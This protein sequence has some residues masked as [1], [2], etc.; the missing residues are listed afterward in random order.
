[1]QK[2][3]QGPPVPSSSKLWNDPNVL[4]IFG[5]SLSAIMGVSSVSPAFHQIAQALKIS[6]GE[7]SYLITFYTLPGV[8]LTPILGILADIFG[9]KFIL[10]PSLLLFGIAGTSCFFISDFEILLICRFFQGVGSAAL[11][12]L[13]ITLIG[14]L[15]SGKTRAAVMG[16]NSSVLSFGTGGYPILG[17]ALAT[18]GWNYPFL[19]P[20]L[21]VVVGLLVIF[22]LQNPEPQANK[23]VGKYLKDV[24]KYLKNKQMIGILTVS[25]LSFVIFFGVCLTYFP[26]FLGNKF[27]TS[28][29]LIGLILS[30]MSLST[31]IT[32]AQ[33]GRL[34]RKYSEIKLLK[35][36]FLFEA[37]SLLMI[38]FL[39]R[40]W[41]MFIPTFIFG[42]G[43]GLNF[44]NVQ[45][46][47]T[48]L[49]PLN[50]RA[51]I[52]SL[53]G[54]VLRVGQT[55]GPLLMAAV[56]SIWGYNAIFLVGVFL[57]IALVVLITFLLDQTLK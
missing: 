9:R 23:N 19:L 52:V 26:L 16:Y 45:T 34:V 1:M 29:F 44:P 38:P 54:M 24:W 14:D 11:G 13:S 10:I 43:S 33:L 3:P 12:S 2:T 40:L 51:A 18:F 32:S 25:A 15:F 39:P 6:S 35:A 53:N 8:I 31:A 47:L 49:A 46:I 7:I 56:W 22:F 4:I 42:I 48:S 21:G 28:P 20:L 17:G 36:A 41:L 37:A 57:A 5:I 50:Q 30:T 27:E 55:I